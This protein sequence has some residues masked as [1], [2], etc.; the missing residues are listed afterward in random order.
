MMITPEN[1]ALK[2]VFKHSITFYILSC[3]V[4]ELLVRQS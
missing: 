2:I 1:Q 3:L 4:P